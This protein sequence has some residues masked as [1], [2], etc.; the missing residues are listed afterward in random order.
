MQFGMPTLIEL[1]S[2]EGCAAL[3][4]ELGLTFIELNMCLPEYQA[5]R[6]DVARLSGIAERYGVFYTVHLDDTNTPCDF[7]DWIA[8]AYT[9]TVLQV[10]ETAKALRIP[11]LNMHLSEGSHFTLP[12]RKALLFEEYGDEYF[13]KL[14]AFR[15]RCETAIGGADVKICVENTRAFQSGL[16]ER[17]LA[18]LLE[19]PVFGVTFDVGH[20]ASGGFL[21]RPLIDRHLPRLRHMH[22]HDAVPGEKR[23]HLPLGEGALDIEEY[24]AIAKTR[25][26]RCVLEVKTVDGLRRSVAWMKE[27]GVK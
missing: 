16:G 24:I 4:K 19:S 9:E 1:R 13:A 18:L 7:N 21:Q 22:I 2:L 6:L 3:C 20:D 25:P 14:T 15:D 23:D 26:C 12:D 8:E 11:V 10:I 17:S 5:E 27:R